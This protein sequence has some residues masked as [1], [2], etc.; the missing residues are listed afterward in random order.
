MSN[1]YLEKIS[2][3]VDEDGGLDKEAS[4]R[5]SREKGKKFPDTFR[6]G[7]YHPDA[8]HPESY[9]KSSN[10]KSWFIQDDV[11]KDL[12]GALKEQTWDSLDSGKPRD[13]E[14]IKRLVRKNLNAKSLLKKAEKKWTMPL[15]EV[16]KEHEDLSKI[17]RSNNRKAELK[18]LK[19]Q[20]KELKEMLA[21]K[22]AS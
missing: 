6:E 16:I 9:Y 18:E 1:K 3:W 12:Y 21:K 22:R 4:T 11:R 20:G 15:D 8:L 10:S 13:T 2:S 7:S 19:E 14:W 5:Y 17:L